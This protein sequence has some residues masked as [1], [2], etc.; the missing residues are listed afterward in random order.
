MI[1]YTY[2]I[3]ICMVSSFVEKYNVK[4]YINKELFGIIKICIFR[5]TTSII[6]HWTA[7]TQSALHWNRHIKKAEEHIYPF[8]WG[9]KLEERRGS[10]SLSPSLAPNTYILR[11]C[12]TFVLLCRLAVIF[13]LKNKIIQV[14]LPLFIFSVTK[15]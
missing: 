11:Y 10:M 12:I 1:I 5:H 9:L 7:H 2:D 15:K 13:E 8:V 14:V 3:N 4:R 6:V